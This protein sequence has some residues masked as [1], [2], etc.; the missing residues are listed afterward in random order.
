MKQSREQKISKGKIWQVYL[1]ETPD[2]IIFEGTKTA[3]YRFINENH[4]TAYKRG[5]IRAGKLIWE[6]V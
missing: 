2:E 1:P 5:S 4:K 6:N 3:V